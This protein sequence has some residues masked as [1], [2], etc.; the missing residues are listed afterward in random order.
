MI[1]QYLS[2]FVVDQQFFHQKEMGRYGFDILSQ[3]LT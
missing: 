3:Q 1:M 2:Y